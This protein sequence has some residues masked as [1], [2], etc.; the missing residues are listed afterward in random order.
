MLSLIIKNSR[1]GTSLM[2]FWNPLN[3]V[4]CAKGIAR[5]TYREVWSSQ[6]N[7]TS[8]TSSIDTQEVLAHSGNPLTFIRRNVKGSLSSATWKWPSCS[9]IFLE[10]ERLCSFDTA[11]ALFIL[12]FTFLP[13]PCSTC[14]YKQNKIACNRQPL[15]GHDKCKW[16]NSKIVHHSIYLLHRSSYS[17]TITIMPKHLKTAK[18]KKTKPKTLYLLT[19][20]HYLLFR[21]GR[22][23]KQAKIDY[24]N[25][26]T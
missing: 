17:M 26:K 21:R 25:A 5:Q 9:S 10:T 2:L 22:S 16:R 7:I 3:S 11:F 13:P 18:P 20:K 6:S 15:H 19:K 8:M 14:S 23:Q 4:A 24:P 12:G 1:D